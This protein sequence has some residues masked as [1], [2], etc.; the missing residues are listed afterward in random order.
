MPDITLSNYEFDSGFGGDQDQNELLKAMQA[1]QITGRDTTDQA[2]LTYQPLKV[3]S[4]ESS[5]RQLTFRMKDIRL[6][7]NIPRL[8]A[9]NTVEEY[10]QLTDYGADRGG[11]YQEGELSDVE[12]SEYFRRSQTV[13]YIQVTGEVTYQAQIVNSYVKPY[14]KEIEHKMM[15]ILRRV[16]KAMTKADA[17]IVPQEFNGL[18]KQHAAIGSGAEFLYSTIDDY[19]NSDTVIDL[20]GAPLTQDTFE[21]A[22]IAVDENFGNVDT[23]FMPNPVASGLAKDYFERQRIMLNSTSPSA[24]EGVVG[25]IPKSIATTVGD[26]D[27]IVDKFMS[28]NSKRETITKGGAGDTSNSQKAPDKITSV[29][30]TV[31]AADG[32]SKWDSSTAGDYGYAVVAINRYGRSAPTFI[33]SAVTAEDGKSIDLSFSKASGATPATGY[34]IFATKKGGSVADGQVFYPLFKVSE[35]ERANGYDGAS[36]GAVRDRNRFLPESEQA[37]LIENADQI[38]SFKQLAP[39]SKLDLAV[40]SMSRR[41]ITFLFG[42]P[43]LY[44]PPKMCRIINIGKYSG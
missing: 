21:D 34:E 30:A 17:D 8:P 40:L 7:Q 29:T 4:L 37:F 22:A 41:F 24:Y 19:F 42:T 38:Y 14:Q 10:L 43:I 16:N 44:Q 23:A 25:T 2:G 12:D 32:S 20:R 31:T 27:I 5:L 1:G 26:V 35:S 18:Y 33:S 36:A 28:Q 3:E 15:W 6:W 13:K 11:F 9:F 39:L